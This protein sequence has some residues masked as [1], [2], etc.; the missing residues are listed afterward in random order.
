MGRLGT[1]VFGRSHT[2][3]AP[4]A[5]A[6]GGR[7]HPLAAVSGVDRDGA[8]AGDHVATS[9]GGAGAVPGEASSGSS[10]ARPGPAW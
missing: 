8:A 1:I 10:S 2:A 4:P 3:L 9:Q 6:R 7:A 5:I